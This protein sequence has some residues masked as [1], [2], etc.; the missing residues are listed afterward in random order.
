MPPRYKVDKELIKH[1]IPPLKYKI[2]ESL[3]EMNYF[4]RNSIMT[5]MQRHQLKGLKEIYEEKLK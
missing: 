4:L 5:E 1:C 2:K 3:Y